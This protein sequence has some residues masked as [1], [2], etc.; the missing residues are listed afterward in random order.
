M[1]TQ[2]GG[3]HHESFNEN[4]AVP[5]LS[6]RGL[7]QMAMG[8]PERIYDISIVSKIPHIFVGVAF[9][10]DILASLPELAEYYRKDLGRLRLIARN[11]ANTI[12]LWIR[13][14]HGTWRFFQVTPDTLLEIDS[15]G[16]RIAFG[17]NMEYLS[18][19]AAREHGGGATSP[20]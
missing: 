9:A 16:N 2:Q 1:T 18:G 12:E 8:G 5:A 14:R 11:A 19:V 7:I 6:G 10:P 13:S 3:T 15:R 4:P 20:S 17:Q